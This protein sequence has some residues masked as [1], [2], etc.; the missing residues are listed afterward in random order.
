[1]PC[2]ECGAQTLDFPVPSDARDHLP[3]ERAGAT[4]CTQCLA[5][6]PLDD[7]PS[8]YPDFTTV[9]EAFPSDGE[10]AAVLACL[11]AVVDSLALYRG[12]VDAL[13]TLAEGRG[14]DVLLFLHR[15]DRDESVDPHFD[16]ERRERQLE[17]LI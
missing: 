12:E 9:S 1:M 3:D 11:L 17:Q 7:P 15:L 8:D 6:T 4:L 16:V 13:A 14:V 5:V 2:P 10:T